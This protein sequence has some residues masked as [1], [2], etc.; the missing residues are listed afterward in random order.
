[1]SSVHP[2]ASAAELTPAL[3]STFKCR[4]TFSSA[5]VTSLAFHPDGELF[6]A[7]SSARTLTLYNALTGTQLKTLNVKKSGAGVV[8]FTHHPNAVLSAGTDEAWGDA[9]RYLSLHDNRDLRYFRGHTDRVTAIE[10]SPVDDTF[11]SASQDN[12]LR[13]W[14]L[15]SERCEGILHTPCPSLAAIDPAGEVIAVATENNC[16]KL[17]DRKNCEAGPFATFFHGGPSIIPQSLTFSPD[18][19]AVIVSGALETLPPLPGPG[20]PAVPTGRI[21]VLDSFKGRTLQSIPVT[22]LSRP[23]SEAELEALG[24]ALPATA[25]DALAAAAAAVPETARARHPLRVSVAPGGRLASAGTSNGAVLT[26]D[27]STGT[28]AGALLHAKQT[29]APHVAWNP[30]RAQLASADWDEIALWGPAE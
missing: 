23:R 21:V 6:I 5:T 9:I 24:L 27:L 17:F 14:D 8:Q 20:A 29:P 26:W 7:A 19:N 16:V 15:R 4:R 22:H 12:S 1:M 13:F 3:V 30:R 11:I 18:G 2:P 28:L 25:G 10:R